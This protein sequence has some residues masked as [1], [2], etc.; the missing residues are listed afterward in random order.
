MSFFSK[1]VKVAGAL[2]AYHLARSLTRLQPRI[3]MYHRFSE[4]RQ[5]G[6]VSAETFRDQLS[7]I[8]KFHNPIFLNDLSKSIFHNKIVS[9]NSIVITVDDGYRDFHDIAF[10]ILRELDV[11]ATLFATTGFVNG[12]LWLWP[13]QVTWLLKH[14]PQSNELICKLG[15]FTISNTDVA[16]NYELTWRALIS[17]LLS[18]P[19]EKKWLSLSTLAES[20][21][22]SLPFEAPREY[23]ACSWSQLAS[24]E[25]QGVEIGG[26]TITHP[27]LGRVSREQAWNEINGCR[28]MLDEQLGVKL[29]PFCYPNGEPSDFSPELKSVVQKSGFSCA[30][31]AF[32]DNVCLRDPFALRRHSSGEDKFQFMKSVSGI[33]TLGHR[34]R[35]TVRVPF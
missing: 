2:G 29:R 22:L 11:P 3:L 19:D 27:S 16:L 15:K 25:T 7:Y 32:A 24:M 4:S 8:K 23:Q 26:H 20:W 10:P 35:N 34:V 14:A 30:V 18:L 6:Y 5:P 21:G 28:Q 33:E 17:Y 1:S 31:T 12:D 9:P 13:D